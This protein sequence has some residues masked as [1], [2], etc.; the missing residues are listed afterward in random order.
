[1]HIKSI[2]LCGRKSS[3]APSQ[4]TRKLRGEEGKEGGRGSK[5]KHETKEKEMLEM[6][7]GREG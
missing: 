4:P 1:M 5:V 3:E 7:S 6:G 2:L